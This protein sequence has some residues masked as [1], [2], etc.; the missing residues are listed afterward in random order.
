MLPDTDMC[1]RDKVERV[2]VILTSVNVEML[3]GIP[4]T[5]DGNGAEITEAVHAL[6]YKWKI[7][8]LV[9][10]VCFDT[11]ASNTVSENACG[12]LL[13]GKL[14]RDLLFL[15]Y[16]WILFREVFE[17]KVTSTSGPD[18]LIFDRLA[19]SSTN[20]NTTVFNSGMEDE[21]VSNAISAYECEALKNICLENLKKTHY[22]NDYRKFLELSLIFLGGTVPN[23]PDFHIPSA[24]SHARFMAKCIYSLKILFFREQFMLTQGLTGCMYL[25]ATNTSAVL[26]CMF[27]SNRSTESGLK[28]HQRCHSI[29]WPCHISCSST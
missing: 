6:L 28:S 8:D 29:S 11:T 3:L 15:P 26:V 1:G 18:V 25:L 7:A 5:Q 12:F 2:A 13:E 9:E 19:K 23:F 14:G 16:L 4:K 10:M 22:R 27:H 24:I 20:I 21:I 17:L